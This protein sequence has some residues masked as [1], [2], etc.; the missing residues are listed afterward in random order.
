MC[1]NGD[2]TEDFQS[3]G[4]CQL[5][6][7]SSCRIFLCVLFRVSALS[8]ELLMIRLFIC[9]DIGLSLNAVHCLI[10]REYCLYVELYFIN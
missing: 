10:L 4:I 9:S 1:D 8:F 3:C 7:V 5:C 6:I 2:L